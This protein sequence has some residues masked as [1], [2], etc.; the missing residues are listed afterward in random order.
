MLCTSSGSGSDYQNYV[1]LEHHEISRFT[2]RGREGSGRPSSGTRSH[3]VCCGAL[4]SCPDGACWLMYA[5]SRS[6]RCRC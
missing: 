6:G 5:T 4:L 3:S 2:S 1:N